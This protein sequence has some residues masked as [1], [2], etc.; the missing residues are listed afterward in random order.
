M[1][2]NVDADSDACAKKF[3]FSS[4]F[5]FQLIQDMYVFLRDF[6]DYTVGFVC[7]ISVT[8]GCILIGIRVS[9]AAR[10]RAKMMSK[11]GGQKSGKEQSQVASRTTITMLT[12]CILFLF[13]QGLSFVMEQSVPVSPTWNYYIV[14]VQVPYTLYAIN[15]SSNFIIYVILNKNFRDTYIN[16]MKCRKEPRNT[17]NALRE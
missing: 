5:F 10:A 13:T 1:D 11:P 9:I 15:S 6:Y 16:L 14:H 8:V 4:T 12:V 7:V 2:E 17:N 3:F